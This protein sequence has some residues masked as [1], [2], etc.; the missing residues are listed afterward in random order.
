MSAILVTGGAGFIGS[1]LVERLLERG[2][3]VVVV[4]DFNDYYSPKLKWRNLKNVLEHPGFHL[5]Q[6]DIRDFPFLERL[7]KR[8]PLKEVIHLAARAGVRPSVEDP[9][10]YEEVNGL[11]TVNLLELCRRYEVPKFIYGG[12]SSVYGDSSKVPFSEEDCCD[13]PVSPYAA[14]KRANEL[15]C[16]AYHHLFGIKVVSLR[17]FTV[18]GPRQRPEMAIHKFTRLIDRGEEIPVFGDGSSRRDYTYIDDII[19][20]V[21]AAHEKDFDFE[22]FNLGESQTTD[23]L[24]LIH[25]IEENL[26]KKAKIKFLPFQPGDVHVTY[27]DISKAKRLLGY[28]PQ[29]PIEQG[30]RRFVDWYKKEARDLP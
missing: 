30:I 12:S 13:R 28:N 24:T 17:F 3:E 26:G 18:Y 4:D 10:L 23:L 2:E 19:Q 22:I 5:E 1:H 7:F 9:I 14:T 21:L 11:G 27:A 16:H 8:Y 29:V 20:G 25:L 6:G 15:I